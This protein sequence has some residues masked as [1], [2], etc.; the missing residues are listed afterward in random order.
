M[1]LGTAK[2]SIQ[3]AAHCDLVGATWRRHFRG[4]W[5]PTPKQATAMQQ[6][7]LSCAI[8]DV[9]ANSCS[10]P[11]VTPSD[12]VSSGL[13]AGAPCAACCPRWVRVPALCRS[14][15]LRQGGV[16]QLRL[17][18]A[19]CILCLEGFLWLQQCPATRNS[20]RP[21]SF[22]P[23]SLVGN[24]RCGT[25]QT[26]RHPRALDTAHHRRPCSANTPTQRGD[27]QKKR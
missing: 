22:S 25:P 21:R 14:K 10:P 6:T 7:R 20:P 15:L 9:L 5:A 3:L 1:P 27:V 2:S 18:P 8:R 17:G 11:R 19:I 26:T 23:A 24:W 4:A 13:P 12:H 16:E